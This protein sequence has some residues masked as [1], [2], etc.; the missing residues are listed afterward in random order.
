MATRVAT[1]TLDPADDVFAAV[2]ADTHPQAGPHPSH[3]Y[4]PSPSASTSQPQVHSHSASASSSA[5]RRNDTSKRRRGS[6]TL[7]RRGRIDHPSP[8]RDGDAPPSPIH[9]RSRTLDD[10]ASAG[11][12]WLAK[13]GSMNTP[14]H[15]LK[16][17]SSRASTSEHGTRPSMRRVLTTNGAKD[18][19]PDSPVDTGADSNA[20]DRE[21]LVIVHEVQPKDSLAGVALKYGITLPELRRA[22]QM[23]T[24]DSIHLR[25]VLYIPVD[26]TRQALHLRG[27][28]IDLTT[29]A[30]ADGQPLSS[31]PDSQ[32]RSSS[33]PSQPLI[34]L[35]DSPKAANSDLPDIGKLTI[36]RVP[37]SQLSYFPPP[38]HPSPMLESTRRLPAFSSAATLP[39]ALGRP[40]RSRSALPS[41]FSGAGASAAAPPPSAFQ[42]LLD[43][44]A[45]SLQRSAAA[46]PHPH[47]PAQLFGAPSLAARLSLDSAPP[48]GTPSSTSDELDWEHELEDVTRSRRK[49]AGPSG[50]ASGGA[51]VA[52]PRPRAPAEDRRA[53]SASLNDAPA[54]ALRRAGERDGVELDAWRP[55]THPTHRRN[56]CGSDEPRGRAGVV[57]YTETDA[58]TEED[59]GGGGAVLRARG[60]E[61]GSPKKTRGGSR[62]AVRTAQMEPS[63]GMQLP[64]MAPKRVGTQA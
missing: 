34:S 50:G 13:Q 14:H 4:A 53:A 33:P 57:P 51:G 8:D 15:P 19:V 41:G 16:H 24:S 64:A 58:E 43:A 12:Y 25:K 22:N 32:E 5:L 17:S 27:A 11:G 62:S 30:A 44:F 60:A 37:A 61:W 46:K 18:D 55:P 23:W 54:G 7:A 21:T 36:R 47:A 2:W 1:S 52:I 35:D 28:L 48:S 6:D 42:G 26:K 29:R 49:H 38:A 10:H 9:G 20:N 59:G 39:T 56:G 63:P 31:Y 45:S 40:K 3:P